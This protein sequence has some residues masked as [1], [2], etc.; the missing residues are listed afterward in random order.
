MGLEKGAIYSRSCEERAEIGKRRKIFACIKK[1]FH[2][3][4]REFFWANLHGDRFQKASRHI[5]IMVR[6]LFSFCSYPYLGK[7]SEEVE[8]C[9]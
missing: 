6:L 4:W 2:L 1:S 9:L 8:G 3:D 7:T 5:Y